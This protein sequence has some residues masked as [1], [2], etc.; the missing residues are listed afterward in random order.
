[1]SFVYCIP[2]T[3]IL[4]N[5]YSKVDLLWIKNVDALLKNDKSLDVYIYKV[6][7]I[8]GGDTCERRKHSCL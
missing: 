2:Q 7:Q 8:F 3:V 4:K 1:M 6:P 5:I